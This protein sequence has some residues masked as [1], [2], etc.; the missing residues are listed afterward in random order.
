MNLFRRPNGWGMALALFAVA[1]CA[2][3]K[4]DWA[5][6]VGNYTFDQAVVELEPDQCLYQKTSR[7]SHLPARTQDTITT[8]L[9]LINSQVFAL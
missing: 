6:R 2:T 7:P 8:L 4:I 1:G 5:G 3:A 9:T